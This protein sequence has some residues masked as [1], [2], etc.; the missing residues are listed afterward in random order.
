MTINTQSYCITENILIKLHSNIY[1]CSCSFF[2]KFTF[3]GI[4]AHSVEVPLQSRHLRREGLQ[5]IGLSEFGLYFC[6]AGSG[7]TEGFER[8][9]P[10]SLPS[11]VHTCLF[12][13]PLHFQALLCLWPWSLE[14]P[15]KCIPLPALNDHITLNPLGSMILQS[16]KTILLLLGKSTEAEATY[17]NVETLCRVFF[18]FSSGHRKSLTSTTVKSEVILQLKF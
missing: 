6:G 18:F 14:S 4:I 5:V 8:G 13:I 11:H 1:T 15:K 16:W 12:G 10:W 17:L 3:H 9:S 7:V 2:V